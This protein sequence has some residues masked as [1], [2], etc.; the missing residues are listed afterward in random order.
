MAGRPSCCISAPSRTWHVAE[1][2][3]S[4]AR[5]EKTV[6]CRDRIRVA[7]SAVSVYTD[8]RRARTRCTFSSW[9]FSCLGFLTSVTEVERNSTA[10]TRSE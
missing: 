4:R 1:T 10:G 8:A 6:V 2:P 5:R 7:S 3:Q 9:N